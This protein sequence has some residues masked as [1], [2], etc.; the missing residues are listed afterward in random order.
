MVMAHRFAAL[1]FEMVGVGEG[2]NG[3]FFQTD[4]TAPTLFIIK[5]LSPGEMSEGTAPYTVGQE[6]E[7]AYGAIPILVSP[8]V[9][10]GR[11]LGGL[12]SSLD[13]VVLLRYRKGS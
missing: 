1:W 7:G 11:N 9:N 5:G 2:Q 13:F 3:N 8:G 10:P 4:N 12:N 6:V